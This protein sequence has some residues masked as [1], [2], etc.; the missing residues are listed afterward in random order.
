MMTTM[1]IA[2]FLLACALPLGSLQAQTQ[3]TF[4][5]DFKT[6]AET[7]MLTLNQPSSNHLTLDGQLVYRPLM[8]TEKYYWLG[9]QLV[10]P[11]L[12]LD[13]QAVE[14][15]LYSVPFAVKIHAQTKQL[16]AH[17]FAGK[18]KSADQQK[19]LAIYQS[20]HSEHLQSL[21]L[22]VP[23]TQQEQDNLGQY[24]VVYSRNADHSIRRAKLAYLS[25]KASANLLEFRL[26]QVRA[27]QF[28]LT[29]DK[30]GLTRLSGQNHTQVES[31]QGDIRI[32][33]K[34]QIQFRYN[35]TPIPATTLLLTLGDDPTLWP[36]LSEAQLYP[37]PPAQPLKDA[38]QFVTL[39]QSQDIS[40][41]SSDALAQLLYDNQIYLGALKALI[42]SQSLSDQALKR[43]FMMV[44][45]NDS[46]YAHQLLVDVYL[47][48]E[49]QGKQ[50]FRSLMGLKYAQQPLNP[51][52]VELVMESARQTGNG[53]QRRLSNSAMMVLG[54]IAHNQQGSEF[55]S[56]VAQRLTQQL[57]QT[58]HS[59]RQVSLLAALGNSGDASQQ[60][61]IAPFLQASEPRLRQ[62]AAESLGKMPNPQSLDYLTTQLSQEQDQ[63]TQAA[64]L[65]A[66]GNNELTSKQVDGL[67]SYSQSQ[68]Q[69]VRLAAVAALAQQTKANPALKPRLKAL[70]KKE[71][72]Q[73]VLRA[74]M[75]AIYSH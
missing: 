7:N 51:E 1:T 3:C 42:K 4:W 16:M 72:D 63:E 10:K 46:I 11:T 53:E 55:A 5:G 31:K 23:S 36:Q 12:R 15:T 52:L 2:R 50:R 47:D 40:T 64:L 35:P 49:I 33:V 73:Q 8:R 65:K 68:P 32:D 9:L 44:G 58:S 54:V 66:I 25:T 28:T 41:L 24:Q 69:T 59:H 71:K 14:A 27:D 13:Q 60:Q 70:V 20:L 48:P 67:F 38:Q 18:L 56:D 74:L 57:R 22:S 45:K 61:Y 29:L 26:P 39:L 62:Q 17:H 43:L 19:L 75:Q 30:C 37:R 34:Q 21:D 6:V